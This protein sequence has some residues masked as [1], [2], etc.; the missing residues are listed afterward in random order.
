MLKRLLAEF[1]G[2]FFLLFVGTGAILVNYATHGAIGQIGI[3]FAFGLTIFVMIFS[4]ARISGAHFNPSVTIAFLAARKIN[5]F[6]AILYII[7]QI[8]G[9]VVGCGILKLMFGGISN[10]TITQPSFNFSSN[11]IP[12]SIAMEFFFTF[13]LMFI[14]SSVTENPDVNETQSGLAIGITV[15]MGALI[16][17]PISGGSFNPART[18]GPAIINSEYNYS[19][20]YVIIPTVAAI[21][22]V[23]TYSHLIS[24]KQPKVQK[25]IEKLASN[26]DT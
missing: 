5:V 23:V 3:S 8:F 24:I 26:V 4:C 2:T 6:E 14:I 13:M 19:W 20:I 15:F 21:S 10:L 18:L 12:I 7:S 22:S 16:A 11:A 25:S 9:A 1:I 17:G